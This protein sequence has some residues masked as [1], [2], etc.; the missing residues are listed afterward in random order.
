MIANYSLI[1]EKLSIMQKNMKYGQG[2]NSKE[3][4]K[5]ISD[6]FGESLDIGNAFLL[7]LSNYEIHNEDFPA[8][9]NIIDRLKDKYPEYKHQNEFDKYIE[10]IRKVLYSNNK[11]E[12]KNIFYDI[13]S[14]ILHAKWNDSL[15]KQLG[16]LAV[17]LKI[18]SI[19]TSNILAKCYNLK[20][21][22]LDFDA[23]LNGRKT[24]ESIAIEKKEL[25]V[26]DYHN[27][28][29]IQNL[30]KLKKVNK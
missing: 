16:K 14:M 5:T 27:P 4:I 9:S 2:K 1:K 25:E 15:K 19:E 10:K 7:A 11:L 3:F 30:L 28:Q 17:E 24:F 18:Y 8:P 29:E 13:A 12:K 21:S 20:Y 26:L 6:F 23:I 22:F